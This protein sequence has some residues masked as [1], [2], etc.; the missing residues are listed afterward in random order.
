ME[1][2]LII[3]YDNFCSAGF[4]PCHESLCPLQD[5]ILELPSTGWRRY[6][7]TRMF[8]WQ[9]QSAHHRLK[10]M[11]SFLH[12]S[13]MLHYWVRCCLSIKHR[14][15]A[16]MAVA[17]VCGVSTVA[18]DITKMISD[19]GYPTVGSKHFIRY[20]YHHSVLPPCEGNLL[21]TT[22]GGAWLPVWTRLLPTLR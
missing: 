14:T 17:V 20:K 3:D 18:A 5:L 4:W 6:V 16:A 8:R 9:S 21:S 13:F 15:P 12:L 1:A 11:L 19:R 10:Y 2:S 22:R 7:P